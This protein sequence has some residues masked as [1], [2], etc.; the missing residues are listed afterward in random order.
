MT[1][2]EQEFNG[3]INLLPRDRE[4]TSNNFLLTDGR[5]INIAGTFKGDPETMDVD[6]MLGS[7]Y[8]DLTA[9]QKRVVSTAIYYSS[10]FANT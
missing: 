1:L 10:T 2:T 9:F 8:V 6:L 4:F 5:G 7:Q 3:L